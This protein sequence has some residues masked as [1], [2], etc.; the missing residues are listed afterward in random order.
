MLSE[1]SEDPQEICSR[2]AGGGQ[3]GPWGE[4]FK[5]EFAPMCQARAYAASSRLRNGGAQL[6]WRLCSALTRRREFVPTGVF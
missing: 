6:S 5:S 3:V 2:G 4:F 1:W